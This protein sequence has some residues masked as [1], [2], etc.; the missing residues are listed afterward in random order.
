MNETVALKFP[1]TGYDTDFYAWSLQQAELLRA[2]RFDLLDI[3]NMSEEIEALGR[4]DRAAIK[5]HIAVL[6]EHLLKLTV[7][8]AVDPR[9]GWK[10]SVR[11]ARREIEFLV[12]DSPSLRRELPA[13]YSLVWRHGVQ[14]AREALADAGDDGAAALIGLADSDA[15]SLVDFEHLLDDSFY[16]GN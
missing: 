16:P 14:A 10:I 15:A 12:D 6:I 8:Q 4:R 7:S 1:G 3:A 2:G 9:R 11:N 13:L 5:S